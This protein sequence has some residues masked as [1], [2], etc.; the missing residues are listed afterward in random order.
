MTALRTRIIAYLVCVSMCLLPALPAFSQVLNEDFN[1][2]TES[3]G[4][5]FHSGPG[6]QLTNDWDDGLAGEN[7]F[8]GT[9]GNARFSQ[10]SALGLATG[11][12]NGTGAG[13]IQVGGVSYDLLNETLDA[14][15]GTGGGAFLVGDGNP[16]TFN[17]TLNWDDGVSGEGAFG[18]T[19]DGAIL[20]GQMAAQGLTSG[21]VS[22]GAGEIS[23]T[24]VNLAGSGT[25]FAGLQWEIGP[26]PGASALANPSFEG[27]GV[28]FGIP[29][30]GT[31]GN[32]FTEDD[33]PRTGIRVAKMFGTFPGNSGFFQDLP[34]QAGQTWELDAWARHNAGDA[35]S[36]TGNTVT[37]TIEFRDASSTVLLTS[38]PATILSGSFTT[39]VWHDV[40]P[41]QLTAPANTTTARAVFTFV[42]SGTQGGAGFID[43]VSFTIVGGPNP[44]DPSN[45]SLTAAVKGT[46][47]GGAGEMLGNF[48]LRIEDADGDR[49]IFHGLANSGF[50]PIG[51]QLSTAVEADANGTPTPGA[52]DPNSPGFTV[53]IAFD[54]D[55]AMPW[56]TGGKLTVDNLVLSNSLSDGSAWF[57]GLFWDQLTATITDPSTWTLTADV[58]GGTIGG[59]YAL[60]LEAFKLLQSGIDESFETATGVGGDIL[61]DGPAIDGGATF[62]FTNNYDEGLT[63][64]GAFGGV[65]GLIDTQLGPIIAAEAITSGGNPGKAARIRVE[66]MVVGPGGG[67]FAG[68]D[69]GGQLLA[70]TDLSQVTLMAE[71]RGTVP[72]SGGF[73]GDYE[74]RLEDSEGDRLYFPMTATG[75][76]QIVGGPLSGAV[77]GPALDGTGDGNFDL[78]SPNYTIV[79]SFINPESTWFFGGILDVDNLMITPATVGQQ[80]G[81]VTF[82]GTSDGTFQPIGG[83][84][85][86]GA[87]NLGDFEEDF[88][89]ATGTGGGAISGGSWDDG[90]VGEAAF[91]GTFG[92][93]VNNGGGSAQTCASCGVGGSKAGQLIVTDVTPNTGGWFAGV[94]WSDVQVDLSGDLSQVEL[95]ADIKGSIGGAGQMLGSYF[96]RI[97]DDGL[98][99]L[100]FNVTADGSFQPVGGPLTGAAVEVIPG[101]D[102]VFNFNQ[103]D[104]NV[105]IGFVGSS[106]NW[107]TGGTLTFDNLFL[108]GVKLSDAD[109]FTVTVTFANELATW[110][111]SG[112]LTVDNL[113]LAEAAQGDLN[114]DG[115]VNLDDVEPF[116][117]A[118]IDPVAYQTGIGAGCFIS[119]ADVNLDTFVDGLDVE[120]FTELL[121]GF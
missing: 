37:M 12:V 86:D 44:V 58:L 97:E 80:I 26:F 91:F 13:R 60:R 73:L 53:V 56:G 82:T 107:G 112:T 89:D 31:F 117:L 110:G 118:L 25:W 35:L 2:V 57:A 30:W 75:G 54:N 10:V 42:Q 29:N 72:M 59:N 32:V 70:S 3:G 62:G 93:A 49:L 51:G 48:Q 43:D 96:L 94:F 74:L 95:S 27:G 115:E 15:T 111:N 38:A 64:G 52:F 92:N 109:A 101:G 22:G 39:N 84:L 40:T 41:V 23:V 63:E 68:L 8:A 106:S 9:A 19:A 120:K 61:L 114:C 6:L 7:A 116:V 103:T 88:V 24:N 76:W 90:I 99:A 4:G 18:G 119:R 1:T 5:P 83:P 47:N 78:D 100:V 81:D 79:V 21:G 34:A 33:F 14:V 87:T 104:Y 36:G 98:T 121:T 85:S 66:N 108:T 113:L 77:E 46:A 50:Q 102:P 16:N 20:N 55:A 45:F 17:F 65:F 105:T 67:W 11:G 28:G 71:I 69:W